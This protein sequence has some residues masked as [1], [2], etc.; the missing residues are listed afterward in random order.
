[1]RIASLV[2]FVAAL[3]PVAAPVRRVDTRDDVGLV[4]VKR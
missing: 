4:I 3:I 1:M 2:Q